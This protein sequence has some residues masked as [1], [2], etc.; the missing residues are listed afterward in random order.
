M[1]SAPGRP[2]YTESTS[3]PRILLAED[4]GEMREMLSFALWREGYAVESMPDGASLLQRLE[5][6]C[7]SEAIDWDLVISDIHMPGITGM[8]VLEYLKTR[9]NLPP[10]MLITAFGDEQ[11][12][13]LARRLGA[14]VLLDKPFDLQDLMSQVRRVILPHTAKTDYTLE[15]PTK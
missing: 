14:V 5:E 11:T 9:R 7:T 6:G 2:I 4:D 3:R 15:K 8:E 1:V 13:K 10:L 12:H